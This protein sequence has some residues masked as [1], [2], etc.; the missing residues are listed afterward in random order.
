MALAAVLTIS[1]TMMPGFLPGALAVQLVDDIDITVAGIGIVVGIF[2]AVAALASPPMGRLAERLSWAP[3]MRLAALVAAVTLGLTPFLATSAL[4][5]AL[6]AVV[7]GIGVALAQ[8][9][10]NLGLARCTVIGR[11]GLVYGFKHAAVPAAAAFAGFAVPLL[12]IPLGWEWVYAV[13]AG[14]ALV[15]ALFIPFD[16]A[17]HEVDDRPEAEPEVRG[18]PTTPLSLLVV[19]ATAAALGLLGAGGLATFIVVY[20][21]DVGFSLA[22]AGALLAVGSVL[23][24]S[25]R[26]FAGWRIDLRA[27]GGFPTVT[28]FLIIGAVGLVLVASGVQPLVVLGALAAFTFGWGWSGLFTFSVVRANP[29]APA[30]STSITQTGSFIG[31]A[32]GPVVFALI[33]EGISFTAAWVAMAIALAAAAGL[34]RFASRRSPS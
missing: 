26:L 7:A 28:V 8:P 9:A 12:A 20:A 24:I 22:F 4:T 29:A 17:A 27:A 18:R 25:M 11:Q 14:V 6:I 10:T 34:V 15:A 2:F 33:A 21:V 32:A 23:G 19:M 1:V 31:G 5:L 3:G 13:A 16:P 30:A